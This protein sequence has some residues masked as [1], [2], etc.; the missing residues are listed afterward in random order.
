MNNSESETIYYYEYA[1]KSKKHRVISE[2]SKAG[3]NERKK[4]FKG[5]MCELE[6]CKKL[7]QLP[8]YK[9]VISNLYVPCTDNKTTEV[10]ILLITNKGV[11]VIES[12]AFNGLIYGNTNVKYW[13]LIYN[14]IQRYSFFNPVWQNKLHINSISKLLNINISYFESIICFGAYSKIKR[15]NNLKKHTKLSTVDNIYEVIYKLYDSRNNYY[16]NIEVDNI[17]TQLLKY[18]FVSN[19]IIKKHTKL[20]KLRKEIEILEV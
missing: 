3:Y 7:N 10:D 20:V 17:Y 19:E 13:K 12:K 15:V 5:N 6:I 18:K 4:L 14:N 2:N 11:F 16:T 1:S 8:F 9:K